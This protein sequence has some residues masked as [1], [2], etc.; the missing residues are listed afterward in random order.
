MI[1]H[2]VTFIGGP[3]DGHVHRFGQN[4]ELLPSL[5]TIEVSPDFVRVITGRQRQITQFPTSTAV[6]CL[7]REGDPP[8]YYFLASIGVQQSASAVEE[9]LRQSA[10]K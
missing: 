9:P 4:L 6:Y 2:E 10:D 8:R 3:L 1:A 5:A 7:D